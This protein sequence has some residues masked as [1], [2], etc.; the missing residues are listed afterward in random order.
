MTRN[1][2]GF[3][4]GFFFVVVLAFA[5]EFAQAIDVHI[6]PV[7][8]CSHQGFELYFTQADGKTGYVQCGLVLPDDYHLVML[9]DAFLPAEPEPFDITTLSQQ[10]LRD[11][12]AAGFVVIATGL[13]IVFG[14]RIII[15]A[16]RTA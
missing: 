7:D 4:G 5:M 11:A 3:L 1:L 16:V 6:N 2:L 12:F 10:R 15:R 13:L 9:G 14:V 8:M